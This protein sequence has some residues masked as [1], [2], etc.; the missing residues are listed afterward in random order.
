MRKIVH[1]DM[2]CFYA[3]VECKM[4]PSLKGLPVAIG[5]PPD[6][7]SV[8]C[9]A[10]YEARK[11]GVRAAMP[12]SRAVRLC[13]QLIIRPPRF[14][15][16]ELESERVR[17]I[18]ADYTS[19]IEPLSLDEAYL[20]VT[21]ASEQY[22]SA[23]AI[24]QEIRK[25]IYQE[26]QLTASAGVAPNKF[27][28]KIASDWKKPNGIFVIRPHEIAD[29]MVNLPVDKIFGVGKVTGAKLKSL[30][31]E[32]CADL[33]TADPLFLK[34]HFGSRS[35][36]LKQYAFG[37]DDR[38]VISE[39]KPKS[40]TVEE[41]FSNDLVSIDEV[42][43]ALPDLY[44]QW[45]RRYNESASECG[46]VCGIV[47]KLKFQDFQQTTHETIFK[48]IPTLSDFIP[49]FE[50]AFARKDKPVRL[51]GLGIRLNSN[52]DESNQQLDFAI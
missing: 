8:L 7:R 20:D 35:Y 25:R 30:G 34:R 39:W 28:A 32:T 4:D 52:Q 45:L 2:D 14:D 21:E 15:L 16:Y 44:S 1:I 23:T 6:S 43:N 46:K 26:T 47:V 3:A 36:E 40:M 50:K 5:G 31:F 12:S 9:T 13:P 17:K 49:L 51:I 19:M 27:L 24:A 10:S 42:L 22:G 33:Q 18:F 41:T 29:F 11:Y 38:P 37:Q 48:K